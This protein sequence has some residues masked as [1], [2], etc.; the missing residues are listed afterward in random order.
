[1]TTKNT[2]KS[3]ARPAKSLL[4]LQVARHG[5]QTIIHLSLDARWITQVMVA[6]AAVWAGLDPV[7]HWL[8]AVAGVP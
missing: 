7:L 4:V 6:A 5:R 1:M 3:R 2:T 8:R